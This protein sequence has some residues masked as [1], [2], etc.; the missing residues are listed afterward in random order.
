MVALEHHCN[1][2]VRGLHP[3]P[4]RILKLCKDKN[5][6]SKCFR[7]ARNDDEYANYCKYLKQ[8]Q[9][10]MT[11][12]NKTSNR[13][14]NKRYKNMRYN[15]ERQ[16]FIKSLDTV[17]R[18]QKMKEIDIEWKQRP[19]FWD[20]IERRFSEMNRLSM[21]ESFPLCFILK[22]PISNSPWLIPVHQC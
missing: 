9:D 17:A 6:D 19:K 10:E 1:E 18:L 5:P 3:F 16:S 11:K 14:D 7:A 21:L 4:F 8:T 13:E 20:M 15:Q 22:A 12:C 2:S